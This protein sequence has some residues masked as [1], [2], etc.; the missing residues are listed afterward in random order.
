MHFIKKILLA[1]LVV[2]I[3]IQFM[4]PARNQS[5]QEEQADISK[6]YSIPDTI[7]ALFKNT[8]FDCHSNNTNYPWYSNIQ[9]MGWL[10]AGDIEN[11]KTKL[12]FSEFGSLSSRRQISKLVDIENRIKDGTMPLPA[13]K[14]MH[15]N[16][17]LTKEDQEL[18]IDW[19]EDTKDSVISNMSVKHIP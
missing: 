15:E 16:A 14:L 5:G 12:N 3:A 10:I 1:I 13:Y 7:Y 2:F 11:G 17:R 18:L 4:Q 6:T 19:I 8:C 9:P